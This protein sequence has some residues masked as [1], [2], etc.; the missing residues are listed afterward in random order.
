MARRLGLMVV[1]CL[2]TGLTMAQALLWQSE[3]ALDIGLVNDGDIAEVRISPNGRYVAFISSANN[4]VANDT[5]GE[6]RSR[7]SICQYAEEVGRGQR[8]PC[9]DLHAHDS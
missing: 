1:G 5:R 3:P 7:L 8:R 2:L 4:L 6:D 9:H